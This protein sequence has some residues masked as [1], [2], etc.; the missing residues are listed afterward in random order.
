MHALVVSG[1]FNGGW[2][3]QGGAGRIARTLEPGI[4]A[5]G[6]AVKVRHEVTAILTDGGRAIGVKA[7]DRRSGEPAEVEFRA[8]I[9][10]SDV[11]ARNTYRRLL[12][13]DG[14]IGRRAAK[15]RAYVDAMAGGLS[16]VMLYLRLDQP[17]SALGVAGENYW[18]NTSFEQDDIAAETAATLAGQPRHAF[19]SFPSAKSETT[20]STPPRSARSCRPRPSTAGAAAPAGGAGA[21]TSS[22]RI[23]SC[24]ACCGSPTSPC[25][26][27]RD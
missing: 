27:C 18:I 3:P 15:P 10:I 21:T 25:P 1:Y 4:E 2:F 26:A 17:V 14:E 13:T 9:V 5:A 23:A 20:V 16:A 7:L 19:L 22:S 8:P 12:P 24:K 6:G 11:G